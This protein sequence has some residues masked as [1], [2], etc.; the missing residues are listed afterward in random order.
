M[1]SLTLGKFFKTM[2]TTG[3]EIDETTD[4]ICQYYFFN[5]KA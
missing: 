4:D 5:T 2:I 3:G 1:S